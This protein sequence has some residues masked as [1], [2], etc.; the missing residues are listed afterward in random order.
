VP[1]LTLFAGPNGSGKST[2][3]ARSTFEGKERILDAD[4]IA[5]RMNASNPAAAAI[6]AGRELLKRIEEYLEQQVSFA[7]EM[8]LSSRGHRN[9]IR[10]AHERG[11]HVR[12][13]FTCV[14]SAEMSIDRVRA[15]VAKGG[16]F[17]PDEDVRRRYLRSITNCKEA[18]RLVDSAK[19]YDNCGSGHRLVLIARGGEIVWQADPL[20]GWFKL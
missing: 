12:L 9:L 5:R 14:E 15:R 8:T 6:E 11:F 16:H 2:L 10:E 19:A 13:I 3:I 1:L 17:I 4:A 7:V 20:P 18:I